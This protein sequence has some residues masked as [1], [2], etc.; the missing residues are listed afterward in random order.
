MKR[1]IYSYSILFLLLAGFIS[2]CSKDFLE[3]PST[4]KLAEDAFYK[5]DEDAEQAIIAVYD[6]LQWHYNTKYEWSS[7]WMLKTIPSDECNTGGADQSDLMHFQR[8]DN[9]IITASNKAVSSAYMLAYYGIYR[10]NKII[11]NLTPDSEVKKRCIAEAKVLRAYNYFEL[12]SLFGGVPIILDALTPG[13]YGIPR[14]KKEDVYA[15]IEKDL[16]DAIALPLPKKSEYAAEEKFRVSLGTAQAMLGKAYL[17]QKKY[18]EATAEFDKVIKSTEYDLAHDF[19]KL[20]LEEEELGSESIFEVMYSKEGKYD[21]GTY[22]WGGRQDECN[23]HIELCGP[24]DPYFDGGHTGLIPGWGFCPPK[25]EIYDAY[26]SENDEIRRR[27]T[28]INIPELEEQGGGWHDEGTPVWG[29]EGCFRVKYSTVAS[30]TVTEDVGV[31]EL[32]YGTNWRIIRYADVL[33]MAAEAYHF[34]GNDGRAREELNKVR[35]RVNLPDVTASGIQLFDAIVKERQL[36]LAFEGFR[37]LDLIRWGKAP[38]VL[39]KYGFK[40]NRNELFPIPE[41]EMLNNTAL[42]LTDQNPGY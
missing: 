20:F 19:S 35:H 16:K 15:Q 13:N 18:T 23:I 34:A 12:V 22:S 1:K 4:G 28:L 24:R 2:G 3:I 6:V 26:T 36:E 17:Y 11:N 38:E 9:F 21:W 7:P 5:T 33:L 42:K 32:N 40:A 37:Y 27:A 10:A 31:R 8:L 25:K 39:G 14:A 30:E 41:E 29:F